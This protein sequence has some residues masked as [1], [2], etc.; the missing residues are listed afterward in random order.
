MLKT[1]DEITQVLACKFLR[2][3]KNKTVEFQPLM[4]RFD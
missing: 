3:F 1:W 2:Q 4:L